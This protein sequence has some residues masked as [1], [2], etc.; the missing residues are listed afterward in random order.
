MNNNKMY[1]FCTPYELLSIL[2][3]LIFVSKSRVIV[4]LPREC[5][6]NGGSY[7]YNTFTC[8]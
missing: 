1:S 5:A 4:Y 6:S 8:L 7:F 2:K 3:M